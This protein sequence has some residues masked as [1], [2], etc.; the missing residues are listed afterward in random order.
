M[1]VWQP[2]VVDD[3]LVVR[4]EPLLYSPRLPIPEH[5]IAS[6][7][8][9]RDVFAIGRETNL[10]SITCD[11]M[12]GKSLLLGLLESPIRGVDEN[13]IVKRLRG[14]IFNCPSVTESQA[15]S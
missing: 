5:D 13:L 4:F 2:H 12:T 9:G 11:G 1:L 14:E 7:T 6:S 10:A 8:A 15:R 3:D